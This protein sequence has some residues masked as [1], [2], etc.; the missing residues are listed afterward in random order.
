MRD[1]LSWSFPLGRM[2][3]ITVRVHWLF[4]LVSA[5]WVLRAAYDK[6]AA[7]NAWID[8]VWIMVIL[9]ICVLLHEFGHCFAGRYME[10]EANEILMWPLGGLAYVQVPHT[11]RANLVTALGGPAVN[12]VLGLAAGLVL[13]LAWD[14]K[15][16]LDLFHAPTRVEAAPGIVLER[17]TGEPTPAV[18]A[19]EIVITAWIFWVNYFLAVVN[20][21]LI[22]FPLDGGR[23]CQSL[24]WPY[25]GYRRATLAA[26]FCG[27][28]VMFLLV[29]LAI[30]ANEVMPLA[31]AIF[32]YVSCKS[33]W[34]LLET[35]GE[36]SLLGYDFSQGYTSLERDEPPPPRENKLSWFQRWKQRRAA[37]R[38]QREQESR[39]A[40]E[41]RMDALLQ[42]V[43]NHG[44]DA[45]TEEEKR[46]MKRVSDRYR[47]R[48]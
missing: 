18:S 42:K 5:A 21:V 1:A 45:L 25:V 41:E 47:N 19:P 26:V 8:L 16:P 2:F 24:L 48:K 4:P 20:L 40:E 14:Y 28:V 23:I 30:V 11:P 43:Q 10:G 46:F 7:S 32:I 36:D 31:L 12:V 37:R 9:F 6:N 22:G 27:F 33:Q 29:V 44:I 34:I 13:M 15:P 39:Q 3:G 17:L 35:G 38:L